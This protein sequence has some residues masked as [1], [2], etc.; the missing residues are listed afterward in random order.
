MDDVMESIMNFVG[1]ILWGL[2]N[3]FFILLDLLEMIFRK[4]AGI[5]NNVYGWANGTKEK[6]DGDLVLYLV[7][8]SIIQQIIMSILILSLFLLIIFTIFA[9]VKNQYAEKQEPIS[10]IINASFKGLFMYLLVPV[11][12]V[13]CLMV[14]NIVLQAIDGATKL[15]NASGVSDGLFTSAVYNANRVRN[16]D[17]GERIE[18]LI[19]LVDEQR[20]LITDAEVIAEISAV[21]G[22]D[23]SSSATISSALPVSDPSTVTKLDQIAQIIDEAYIR[24]GNEGTKIN[25]WNFIYINDYYKSTE[26]SYITIWIG[27]VFLIMS[28]GKIAW[29]MIGRLFKMVLFYAISPAVVA[30]FPLDNGKALGSWRSEMVKLGTNAYCAVGVLNV[31]YSILPVFDKFDIGIMG[32]FGQSI[33]KLLLY[34]IAFNSAKDLI[35]TISGWFGT[36][37]AYADGEGVGKMATAPIKKATQKTGAFV[38]G[39]IF[40]GAEARKHGGHWLSGAITGGAGAAGIKNPFKEAIQKNKKAG[41]EAYKNVRTADRNPFKFL[42]GEEDKARKAEYEKYDEL[43]KLS[44]QYGEVDRGGMGYVSSDRSATNQE[45]GAFLDANLGYVEDALFGQQKRGLQTR[46]EDNELEAQRLEILNRVKKAQADRATKFTELE[47]ELN[48]LGAS[49]TTGNEAS[50]R[51]AAK[52]VMRNGAAG[53][54]ST[55]LLQSAFEAFSSASGE[56]ADA[57]SALTQE[58]SDAT[59]TAWANGVVNITD[60]QGN[61]P[62]AAAAAG[63]VLDRVIS[64]NKRE[65]G[66][67]KADSDALKESSRLAKQAYLRGQDAQLDAAAGITDARSVIQAYERSHPKS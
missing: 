12:T 10:K 11:A 7:Q 48:A 50:V 45:R 58:M 56:R 33:V 46:K 9:I 4:F 29:G 53:G 22:V 37:N 20:A 67:I 61:D 27:G 19:L 55:D 60:L 34:I 24:L 59:F 39:A 51:A 13:V 49:F 25:K 35:G 16:G 31:L 26:I 28:I 36:G 14:G 65:T 41:E 54:R 23:V 52:R 5:D 40:G 17:V 15:N 3:I 6:V 18:G 63:R 57:I 44:R 62:G 32:G 66:Q 21:T 1:S 43:S 30:T 64:T 42:A 47:A 38:G 2:S 8:S